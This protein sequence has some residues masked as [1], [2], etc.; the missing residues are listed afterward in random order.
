M[1]WI[2]S[3]DNHNIENNIV[4]ENMSY[5]VLD[6]ANKLLTLADECCGELM[7]NMKL[8]KMLYYQQGYHL[9][10]FDEPLFEDDLEAWMYGPAVP[11]V[12]D[13]YE[14]NGNNGIQP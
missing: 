11:I 4:E 14:I 8:Q 6:I 12:Y 5:N 10:L 7:S 3:N 9:A 2:E 1:L 13:Y